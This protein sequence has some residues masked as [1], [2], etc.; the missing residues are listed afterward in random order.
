MGGIRH[1]E[2]WV[3]DLSK[4]LDFYGKI[5]G[6]VGWERVDAN[7]FAREGT[8]IYFL[9]TAGI[10]GG[11]KTPGPRHIC[12]QV[13]KREVV[14]AVATKLTSADILHGPA[15]L[16]PN[17]SYMLVFKDPDGYILE[18]ACKQDY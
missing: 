18:V 14:D 13:E 2:F 4:S 17:G 15:V 9:E 16:Y 3:A 8:K 6:L 1:I 7:G 10:V 5:L 11:Q 12:F